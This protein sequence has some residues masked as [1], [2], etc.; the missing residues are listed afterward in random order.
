[1]KTTVAVCL[2]GWRREASKERNM[3]SSHFCGRFHPIAHV[4]AF[5]VVEINDSFHNALRLLHIFGTF[6]FVEPLL[7]D[8]TVHPFSFGFPSSV[9][10][11]EAPTSLSLSTYRLQQYCEPRSE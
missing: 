4:W 5:I 6:H 7:L 2:R 11:M 1:M 8:D 9:M 10:L 3:Q